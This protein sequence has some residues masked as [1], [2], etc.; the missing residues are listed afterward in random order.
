MPEPFFK[1]LKSEVAPLTAELADQFHT[2]RAS[3]T[4]R[5][6]SG[7]RVDHLRD[8]ILA[9]NAV[10]FH[11]ASALLNGEEVRM[12]GNHS[13]GALCSLNGS[14]PEGLM[15]NRET[16]EVSCEEGLALLFR[17]FDDRKSGRTPADVSGAYQ[18]LYEP[19]HDVP[20][21]VAKLGME[22]ITW[23]ERHVMGGPVP[24]GDDIYAWFANTNH[25]AYLRWLGDTLTIKTPEMARAPVCAAMYATFEVNESAA[26]DFWPSV[27]RG[28]VE[29]EEYAPATVLDAWLK[30]QKDPKCKFQA[31]PLQL[32]QGCI[33]AWTAY[34]EDRQPKAIKC[35]TGKGLHDVV[36]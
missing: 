36:A 6:L 4:E 2:M 17:Q 24:R 35:D 30:E 10:T 23:H 26:R 7:K 31:K 22:A 5:E 32:Y 20:R 28:G 14:F 13:S 19:L 25:H 9:G 12:N 29:F 15:V 21:G 11:W 27:A 3:P 18:G 33:Y 8:K 1:L 16:Y 34:R